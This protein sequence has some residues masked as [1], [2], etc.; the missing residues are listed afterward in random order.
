[1][2]TVIETPLFEK[3]WPRYWTEDERGRFAA[4]ISEHPGARDVIPDSGGLRK[5][6]WG[7]AASGKSGGVRVIFYART[8]AGDLLILTLYAKSKTENLTGS[9]LKRIRDA[10]E[11]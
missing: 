6:R 5:F 4:Y 7:R 2:L 3:Q 1:M 8:V 11:N 9:Q 10:L